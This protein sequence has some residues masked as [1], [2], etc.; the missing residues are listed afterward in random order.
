MI[1]ARIVEADDSFGRALGCKLGAVD[2]RQS[3]GIAGLGSGSRVL[4]DG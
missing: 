3:G 2:L 4:A 1:E